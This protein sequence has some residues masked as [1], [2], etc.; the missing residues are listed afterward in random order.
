MSKLSEKVIKRIVDLFGRLGS[1]EG[2]GAGD[3]PCAR[4][5]RVLST[6]NA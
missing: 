5:S 2:G 3:S 6:S 4:A 1:D